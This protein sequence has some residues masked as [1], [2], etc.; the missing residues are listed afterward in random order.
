VE[1]VSSPAAL[2]VLA[3]GLDGPPGPGG[4]WTPTGRLKGIP[5]RATREVLAL[6]AE[7]A[8]DLAQNL[9]K[10]TEEFLPTESPTP[11]PVC[12]AGIKQRRSEDLRLKAILACLDRTP[13]IGPN[14]KVQID[15]TPDTSFVEFMTPEELAVVDD[16][17]DRAQRRAEEANEPLSSRET[18]VI[19]GSS[20]S[21]IKENNPAVSQADKGAAE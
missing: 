10:I 6:L 2:G 19:S 18:S 17:F 12:G 13:G 7:H 11:C 4:P 14:Q 15:Q 5:N 20:L 9:L 1:K 8:P 21:S 3:H 16:I